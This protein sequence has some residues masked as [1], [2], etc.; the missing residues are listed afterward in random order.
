[1]EN[2]PAKL[3]VGSGDHTVPLTQYIQNHTVKRKKE[4]RP[5][6]KGAV[7]VS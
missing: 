3:F 7:S 4:R 2:I 6:V 5:C 1:M